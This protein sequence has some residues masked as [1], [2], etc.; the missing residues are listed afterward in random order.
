MLG[1][2]MTCAVWLREREGVGE[3]C[4]YRNCENCWAFFC[5]VRHLPPERRMHRSTR[6]S[7]SSR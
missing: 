1:E 6:I 3:K 7:V 2:R 4:C 5:S